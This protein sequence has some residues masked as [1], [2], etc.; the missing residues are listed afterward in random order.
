MLYDFVI[1]RLCDIA[2]YSVMTWSSEGCGK[3]VTRKKD[4]GVRMIRYID[5]AV[6]ALAGAETR[7]KEKA[8]GA[9]KACR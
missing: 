9:L 1:V 2:R 6:L 4:W 5:R 8:S 7:D 3:I